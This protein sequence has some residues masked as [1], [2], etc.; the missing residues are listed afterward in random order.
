MRKVGIGLQG[1]GTH[2]AFTW[3]A[4]DRILEEV[5]AGRLEIAAISGASAGALNAAVAACGLVEGGPTLARARL[6]EFWET[7]SLRGAMAGNAL[8]YGDPGWFGFNIDW[9]PAA[10]A[11]E[12]LGLV[13]SPYTNPFYRD[14]LGP[15][16]RELLPPTRLARLNEAG[17]PR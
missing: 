10:I 13:V 5:E 1:G 16:L 11:V 4:L 3:G 2:G 17:A 8:V 7:V 9:S 12:A 15:I 14:A 6:R